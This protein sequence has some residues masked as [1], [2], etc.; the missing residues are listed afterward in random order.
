MMIALPKSMFNTSVVLLSS[1]L[2]SSA[3]T[4]ISGATWQSG[5]NNSSFLDTSEAAKIS[6]AEQGYQSDIEQQTFK[7][8]RTNSLVNQ[9]PNEKQT[10]RLLMIKK[11]RKISQLSLTNTDLKNKLNDLQR[12]V[13]QLDRMLQKTSRAA[14]RKTGAS[15]ANNNVLLSEVKSLKTKLKRVRINSNVR[16][17][18]LKNIIRENN[19]PAQIEC[20][21]L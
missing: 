4:A 13:V 18:K 15:S 20:K 17:W 14:V 7:N 21:T 6:S 1:L 11:D 10:F 9:I 16:C 5:I 8:V 12:R 2:F 19:L 3:A